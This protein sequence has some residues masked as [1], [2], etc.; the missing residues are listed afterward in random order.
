MSFGVSD[1][2]TET[3]RLL[4]SQ[5]RKSGFFTGCEDDV[6]SSFAVGSQYTAQDRVA[7]V[8]VTGDGDWDLLR[9]G[10]SDTGTCSFSVSAVSAGTQAKT[11]FIL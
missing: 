10:S 2:R 7:Q 9:I 11:A 5:Q 4:R 3:R 8:R 1:H 6:L